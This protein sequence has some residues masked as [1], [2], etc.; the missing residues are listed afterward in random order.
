MDQSRT[1]SSNATSPVV[2]IVLV[3]VVLAVAGGVLFVVSRDNDTANVAN[4]NSNTSI[5]NSSPTNAN[6]GLDT[7]TW[8]TYSNTAYNYSF[9]YPEEWTLVDSPIATDPSPTTA[10]IG[11]G[12]PTLS[13]RLKIASPGSDVCN[14]LATCVQELPYYRTDG[15]TSSGFANDVVDGV[16]SLTETIQWPSGDVLIHVT[17]VYRA[18]NFLTIYSGGTRTSDGQTKPVYDAVVSSLTFTQ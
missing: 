3:V 6:T 10:E 12:D 14:S 11:F 13:V 17:Y 2:W 4:S 1:P 16:P 18:G 7:A 9:R 5:V 15:A 8:K